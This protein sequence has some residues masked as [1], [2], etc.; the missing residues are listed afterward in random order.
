MT[1]ALLCVVTV[2]FW[3][4]TISWWRGTEDMLVSVEKGVGHGMQLNVDIT[5]AMDCQGIFFFENGGL[6]RRCGG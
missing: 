2:L 3:T 4:E 5:V 1:I 6:R